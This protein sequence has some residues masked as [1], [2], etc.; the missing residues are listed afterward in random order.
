[1][2]PEL[3][4]CR[5]LPAVVIARQASHSP[6]GLLPRRQQPALLILVLIVPPGWSP[7][8]HRPRD[9]PVQIGP[10]PVLPEPRMAFQTTTTMT[11]PMTATMI[12][13]MLRPV[14]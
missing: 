7:P 6:L 8:I 14:M 10:R 12:V 1:M 13:P 5:R 9:S 3:V 4:G 11:A 2:G